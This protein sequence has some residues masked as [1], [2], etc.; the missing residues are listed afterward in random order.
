MKNP[1]NVFLNKLLA[2]ISYTAKKIHLN[3]SNN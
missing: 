2:D 3:S 1:F